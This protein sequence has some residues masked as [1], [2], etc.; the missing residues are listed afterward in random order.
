MPEPCRV[1]GVRVA[2]EQLIAHSHS[3]ILSAH[4]KL[5]DEVKHYKALLYHAVVKGGGELRVK[6]GELHFEADLDMEETTDPRTKEFVVSV[7]DWM[8]E[9]SIT[10]H[11]QDQDEEGASEW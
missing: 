11:D 3:C 7:H 6:E 10:D 5:I 2:D 4:D 9:D 1:C 8:E